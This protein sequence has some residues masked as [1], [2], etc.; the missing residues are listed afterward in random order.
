MRI[1]KYEDIPLLEALEK[2]NAL[3][4]NQVKQLNAMRDS[5]ESYYLQCEGCGKR[6]IDPEGCE[7]E[8]FECTYL[9]VE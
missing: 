5:D 6:V 3:T 2:V 7:P 8:C 9:D 4:E 1:Y